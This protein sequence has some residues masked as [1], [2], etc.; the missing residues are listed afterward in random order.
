MMLGCRF[1]NDREASTGLA[2]AV[3]ASMIAKTPNR[4]A[5]A[6][7]KP[8]SIMLLFLLADIMHLHEIHF[9]L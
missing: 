8:S 3:E 7:N 6:I 1:V 5:T 2:L 4:P 9:S